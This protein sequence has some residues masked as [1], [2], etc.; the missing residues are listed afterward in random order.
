MTVK[1]LIDRL[2]KQN[3]EHEVFLGA[4]GEGSPEK[5]VNVEL[6]SMAPKKKGDLR[7]PAV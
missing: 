4:W 3:P 1:E 6:Y 5:A 2:K 7:W